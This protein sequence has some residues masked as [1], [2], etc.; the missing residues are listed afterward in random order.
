MLATS[1]FSANLNVYA[2]GLKITGI[3]DDRKLSISYFLNAPADEV[4]FFTC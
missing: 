3:T 2:S 1:A 4:V